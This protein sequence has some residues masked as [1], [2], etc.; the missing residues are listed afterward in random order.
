MNSWYQSSRGMGTVIYALGS[1]PRSSAK[2]VNVLNCWSISTDSREIY[3][4]MVY[5]NNIFNP[6]GIQE[7]SKAQWT[8]YYV[9]GTVCGVYK[10][11]LGVSHMGQWIKTPAAKPVDVTS[12][13]RI[14]VVKEDC[15]QK[16]FLWPPYTYYS[17]HSWPMNK[18]NTFFK[19]NDDS[20]DKMQNAIFWLTFCC[21]WQFKLCFVLFLTS[22]KNEIVM[23]MIVA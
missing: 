19:R 22:H 4:L 7:L 8:I 11:W 14:Y 10:W 9:Y 2:R 12:I 13:P 6:V 3:F 23:I 20:I 15:L 5:N 1:K 16:V 18:I 17:S 21:L